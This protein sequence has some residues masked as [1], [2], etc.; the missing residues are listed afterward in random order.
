VKLAT[1]LLLVA[2]LG[3]ACG[4]HRE[5]GA[6]PKCVVHLYF[7][8]TTPRA[9]V[10]EVA[11]RLRRYDRIARVEFISKQQALRIVR[12]KFPYLTKRLPRNPLPDALI[13]WPRSDGERDEVL[14]ALRPPPAGVDRV[15]SQSRA[16]CG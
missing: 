11:T 7:E 16:S 8:P 5:R 13:V 9:R 3:A 15:T 4:G 10:L 12:K 14:R 1:L 2:C 6:S